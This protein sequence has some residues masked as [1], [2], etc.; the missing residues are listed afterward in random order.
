MNEWMD[1][2]ST[3]WGILKDD[4]VIFKGDAVDTVQGEINF[5]AP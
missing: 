4:T 3:L 5:D 2:L 1:E